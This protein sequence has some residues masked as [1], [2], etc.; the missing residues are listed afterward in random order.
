MVW[1]NLRLNFAFFTTII[2]RKGAVGRRSSGPASGLVG[3]GLSVKN[4]SSGEN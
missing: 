1:L 3:G 4:L 2:L